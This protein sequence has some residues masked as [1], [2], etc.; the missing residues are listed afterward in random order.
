M[1]HDHDHHDHDNHH[2][3]EHSHASHAGH[4]HAPKSFGL[5]FAIGVSLNF[6]FVILEVVFGLFAHSL[7]LVADAGHNMGDVLGLLLAWGASA[8]VK[9]K[10]TDKHTY[11]LRSSS[12]LAA[13]FNAIFLLI[14]VGAIA[15]EAIRRFGDPTQVAG[16]T[17]V[18]VSLVGIA[19]NLATALLFMSGRKGDLN[20]R[21]AFLHMA[22]DAGV[23]AGV[24][25]AGVIIIMT[26]LQWI[27]P[28]ISLI[29][30]VVIVWGTWGLLRDSANLALQ[31]VPEEIQLPK[32]RDYLCSLPDVNTVHDLHVWP[33]STTETA[34]TA[35]LE[36]QGA[37][38]GDAFLHEVCEQLY[39]QFT[40]QHSTIQIERDA[41]ACSLA[42]DR[43]V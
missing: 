21:A 37:H 40:I 42:P 7:A 23:S 26:G 31:A 4:S 19:I 14:S 3:H 5:A 13:L 17:V 41:Q 27:D 39:K 25:V 18:W 32:V 12:I 24:V 9:T 15:W 16:K 6:G 34:L 35:H 11:G 38:P 1:P 29:I 10:A 28:V 2:D 43:V 30:A 8:L 22:A 33:M 36:M 20:I